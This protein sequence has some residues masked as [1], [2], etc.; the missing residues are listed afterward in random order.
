MRHAAILPLLLLV[1]GCSRPEAA[2]PA[3]PKA[4]AKPAEKFPTL[5]AGTPAMVSGTSVVQVW[6]P[7]GGR[8]EKGEEEF[9]N[10][11]VREGDRL[12]V[13]DDATPGGDGRMPRVRMESGEKDGRT[14][15]IARKY[16][17]PLSTPPR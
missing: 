3:A 1:A 10:P 15:L 5:R 7:E 14:Y 8:W 17:R 12:L 9:V 4:A 2:V 6:P 13:L 11:F 16:I